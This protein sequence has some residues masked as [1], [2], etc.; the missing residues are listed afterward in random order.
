MPGFIH[1]DEWFEF[2]FVGG[3]SRQKSDHS[4]GRQGAIAKADFRLVAGFHVNVPLKPL[5]FFI[6]QFDSCQ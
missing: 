4:L 1:T 6:R 3:L 5:R 2:R